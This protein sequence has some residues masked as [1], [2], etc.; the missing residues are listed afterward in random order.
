[1]PK[2]EAVIPILNFDKETALA[3]GYQAMQQL[4]WN[5]LFAGEGRLV[6]ITTNNWKAR[7]Q[8]IVLRVADDSLIIG[9]EMVNGE[10]ADI[11]GKNKK[12]TEA[13]IQAFEEAKTTANTEAIEITKK[14]VNLLREATIKTVEEEEKQAAEVDEAMNL[15]GS[16]LY[17]TYAI[18]GINVLVFILM[19]VNGGGLFVAD[20]YVHIKWGSN[21]TPLT[22][23][24]DWWRLFTNIFIHFGIIHL[25]MNMYCLYT[26]GIYLEPMLGKT[27]YITAYFCTGVLASIVSL[28]WHK[29]G[30]NSAGASGTI[31]G[32][33]G[34]F[35]ALL[36]TQ[37]IP[38]K[39]R[40]T[41]LQSIGF[42]VAYNLIYGLKSGV[43][44]AAH[45]GGL[46][47][48]FIIG[49]GYV[50]S[51]KKEKQQQ[52]VPWVLPAAILLTAMI[53][54]G[55]L[56]Q[57]RTP[58]TDRKAIK[59][60]VNAATFKDNEKFNKKL[61]TFDEIHEAINNIVNDTSFTDEELKKKI[62]EEGLPK[63]KEA[64]L[65]FSN[66]NTFEISPASHT[67]AEKLL[68]YIALRKKE[69][70]LLKQMIETKKINELMP[71]LNDVREKADSI[72]AD[73]LKP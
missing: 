39:I 37:L 40:T 32:I 38:K 34:L 5:I 49:Y 55:Y 56:Q 19:A 16:N 17:V 22:L 52:K 45:I 63:L 68:E 64:A 65:L 7:G 70:E 4:N 28:W 33:Y 25:A 54:Y 44:N 9:S 43:D 2:N 73:V 47:S 36:T 10:I 58:E 35:L 24:G 27:R 61:V 60:E 57:N 72:F 15:S 66:T 62:D 18:I 51:V 29:E 13:F 23:S 42:F 50:Y 8:Q 1:M 3:I 12:N 59:N 11:A 41:L 46:I 48:G 31:F 30:V 20:G 69:M 14:A 21:Y 53:T 26:V 67:K 6:G 71:Q